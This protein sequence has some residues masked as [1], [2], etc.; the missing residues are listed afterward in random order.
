MQISS[1]TYSPVNDESE[2]FYKLLDFDDKHILELGCGKAELTR[3]I[4]SQGRGRRIIA[5]EVDETQ[6]QQNLE[7]SVPTNLVFKYGGAEAIPLEDNSQDIVLMFKSLH[8]VPMDKLQAA[9]NEIH[10]VLKAGGM[11]YI[12]EPVFGGDFN[13]I[14]RLFHDEEEV[15]QVAFN[16]CKEAIEKKR[17]QLEKEVFFSIP[18][19][20]NSFTEFE[21]R[22][23]NVSH[24]DHRLDEQVLSAVKNRYESFAS[25]DILSLNAPHRVDLLS[26]IG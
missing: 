24:T 6:H 20:F 22:L 14:L 8:H 16:A 5:M 3:S 12:S 10:R 15:R 17:F 21:D 13:E 4:A 1:S 19:V 2:I 18:V 23:I 25:G 7:S 9:I 11:L 26:K